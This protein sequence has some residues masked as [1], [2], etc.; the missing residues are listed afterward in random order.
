M[1]RG[2]AAKRRGSGCETFV[3]IV[4][5]FGAELRPRMR[6]DG[7]KEDRLRAPVS[8]L[9]QRI[10]DL[11][12][13]ALVVHDEVVLSE[14]RSRPDLAVDSPGGRIGYVELKAPGKGTPNNW[15]PNAHDRDQWE[16]LKA[17]PNLIYTDGSSWADRGR[18][19]PCCDTRSQCAVKR[20]E[21]KEVRDLLAGLSQQPG[22]SRAQSDPED[23]GKGGE[24]R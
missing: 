13:M 17:L 15:R 21:P 7:R 10:G 23:A 6:G 24:Q 9:I 22:G 16:K 1:S 4:Q 19:R 18:D 14:L 20:R 3:Q 5:K 11:F 12:G 8:K 2:A